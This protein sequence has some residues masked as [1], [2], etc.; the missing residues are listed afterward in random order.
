M[1]ELNAN[2]GSLNVYKVND[3]LE[4]R[5]LR[6]RP[7]PCVLRGDAALRHDRGRL[8][9]DSASTARRES[10]FARRRDPLARGH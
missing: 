9:D 2:L 6:V 7:E 10:L 8:H 5:D 3:P 1:R 4:R